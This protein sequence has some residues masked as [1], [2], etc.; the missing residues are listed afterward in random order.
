[1]EHYYPLHDKRSRQGGAERLSNLF[2]VCF[3]AKI[4]ILIVCIWRP[5]FKD[6]ALLPAPPET[7]PGPFPCKENCLYITLALNG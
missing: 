7:P 5:G 2:K 1:M 4:Q 3:R 6:C